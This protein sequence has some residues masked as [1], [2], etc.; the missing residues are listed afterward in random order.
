MGREQRYVNQTHL[1]LRDERLHEDK[2]AK[3]AFMDVDEVV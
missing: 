2:E 1:Y 3:I